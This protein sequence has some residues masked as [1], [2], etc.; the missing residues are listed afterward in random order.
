M[1][2]E[3]RSEAGPRNP[4]QTVGEG[5]WEIQGRQPAQRIDFGNK[6]NLVQ[7]IVTLGKLLSFSE[8][9]FLYLEDWWTLFR[10]GMSETLQG[11][12]CDGVVAPLERLPPTAADSAECRHSFL[13]E[14]SQS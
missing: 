13:M 4:A 11:Y 1:C 2:W 12:A 5:R 7:V 10:P 6:K 3:L 9:R 8:L 14:A